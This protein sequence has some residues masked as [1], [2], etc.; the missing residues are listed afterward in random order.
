MIFIDESG[1]S[2]TIRYEENAWNT[3]GDPYFV[4]AAIVID[5]K[6]IA[7]LCEKMKEMKKKYKIQN[8]F[9]SSHKNVKK[10]ISSIAKDMEKIVNELGIS[11]NVEV[12]NKKYCIV[13]QIVEYCVVPYYDCT[14]ITDEREVKVRRI[15]ANYIYD[16]ISDKLLGEIVEMFDSNRQDVNE[17]IQMCQRLSEEFDYDAIRESI[18]DTIYTLENYEKYHLKISNLFPLI[19]MYNGGRTAVSVCPHID[20][21]N[22]IMILNP[23]ENHIIHDEI[24]ELSDAFGLNVEKYF[25]DK[26][27]EFRKSKCDFCLQ[28]ADLVAGFVREYVIKKV[29][30]EDTSF[31][32]P[33]F[34]R[35][36]EV[37]TNVVASYDEQ[38]ELVPYNI[39][40]QEERFWYK[41]LIKI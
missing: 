33:F 25:E 1:H 27:I 16:N 28:F 6:N 8:E 20:S 41:D 31:I 24:S 10:N 7:L 36:V 2:G 35:I 14:D 40:L 17:L 39:S 11:I 22:H 30:K 12:V 19:D 13:K 5:E 9:K 29:E 34:S 18:A 37:D 21:L 4:L 38:C 3:N 23:N 26:E 32:P 15:F